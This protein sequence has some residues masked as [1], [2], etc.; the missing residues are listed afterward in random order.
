MEDHLTIGKVSAITHI[1]ERRLRYYDQSGLCS[2]AYRDHATGYRYYTAQQL[3]RLMWISY[4]RAL[5]M[6]VHIIA[7]FSQ[8]QDLLTLKQS[9]DAQVSRNQETFVRAQYQYEQIYEFRQRFSIGLSHIRSR[10]QPRM[11]SLVHTEPFYV[12]RFPCDVDSAHMTDAA[13][14]R[15]FSQLD[16]YS[17]RY[18]FVTVGGC[19]IIYRGH[20]L[21]SD[22]SVRPGPTTVDIQIKN[23]PSIPADF[24]HYTRGFLAAT[25]VH[26]GPYE[27][28]SETYRLILEWARTS[29]H[30]LGTDVLEDYQITSQMVSDPS[31]Y[32]TQI[33]IPLAG[34]S[35]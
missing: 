28:L 14:L 5:D 1:S 2:P 6:P 4:M 29:G 10:G 32:V 25:A 24:I 3:P 8:P 23:P 15:F 30:A 21:L 26:V 22:A 7:G 31:L 19:D 34:Q 11:V 18:A 27:T 13:R 12:L 17:Q 9:I 35:L 16:E 20:P 33:Y